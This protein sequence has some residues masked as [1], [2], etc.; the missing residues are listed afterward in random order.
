MSTIKYLFGS[1][2]F[3][4][5]DIPLSTFY[6]CR[7]RWEVH[8]QVLVES[9]E[10]MAAMKPFCSHFMPHFYSMEWYAFCTYSFPDKRKIALIFLRA[11]P[12]CRGDFWEGYD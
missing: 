4:H 9:G 7:A 2:L 11:E 6:P 12:L 3:A 1:I 8:S 5:T 10:A